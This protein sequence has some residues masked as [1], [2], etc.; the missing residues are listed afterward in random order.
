MDKNIEL[1]IYEKLGVKQ[2]KKFVILLRDL[3]LMLFT[4]NFNKDDI[5]KNAVVLKLTII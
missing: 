2:F 3:I 4:M 5:E 1:E